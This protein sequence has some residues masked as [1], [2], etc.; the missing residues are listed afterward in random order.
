MLRTKKFF[1]AVAGLLLLATSA[2]FTEREPNAGIA[3]TPAQATDVIVVDNLQISQNTKLRPGLY[4]LRDEGAEGIIQIVGD[5][6]VVDAT[7]VTIVAADPNFAGYG[8]VASGRNNFTLRNITISG[9]KR[10]ARVEN[11]S[12]ARI[13][14]STITGTLFEDYGVV[15]SGSNSLTLRN[16]TI[17]GFKYGV[18]I[19]NASN[20]RIENSTITGNFKD[21][22]TCFLEINDG[23]RYGGGILFRNVSNSVV[24]GNKLYNQS[25]GLEMIGGANN[26]VL[27]NQ[28]SLGPALNEAQQNSCWGIRLDGSMNN[29]VRGNVADYVDRKR[30]PCTSECQGRGDCDVCLPQGSGSCLIAGD[31]AGIL[32]VSGSHRNQII[33]NSFTNSGDGFFIG[34]RFAGASNDNYVY[35]NDGSFSPSNAF[36][37]TFSRGNVFENNEAS[38]SN[39]GFWLGYS[40]GSRI[41]RNNIISNRTVGIEIE[42][43]YQNEIDHNVI[44]K[45]QF[46]MFLRADELCTN[47]LCDRRNPT[48]VCGR[49]CP[50]GDYSIHDNS[51]VNNLQRG[52][53]AGGDAGGIDAWHNNMLCGSPGQPCDHAAFNEMNRDRGIMAVRNWW[54]TT[55]PAEIKTKIFDHEDD[56]NKGYVTFEPSLPGLIEASV[57]PQVLA[58][59]ATKPLPIASSA[60]FDRRG[61]Q[62]VFHKNRIYVFG[63]ISGAQRLRNVYYGDLLP[64]GRVRAWTRT[65]DMPGPLHDHVVV[66]VG[67]HV[68]L[69]TGAA[70]ESAVYHNRIAAN[71]ALG[72]A[73]DLE[74]AR[75]SS[76]QSFAA[77]SYGDFIYVA[78]GNSTGVIKTVSYI[79]VKPDGHLECTDPDPTKCWRETLELPE[80]MQSHSLVAYD[81]RL[82]VIATDR[83]YVG[84]NL[85]N[86]IFFGP[87][88]SDGSL[89]SWA[90][91]T[92]RMPRELENYAA[93]ATDSKLYLFAG[94][95]STPSAPSAFVAPLTANGPTDPWQTTLNLPLAALLMGTRVGAYK[96]FVYTVGGFDGT[97]DKNVV[98]FGQLEIPGGCRG[99]ENLNVPFNGSGGRTSLTYDG[100][101][102][103]TVSGVGQASG[104]NYS[105]AFYVFAD[106]TGAPVT[107]THPNEFVLTING[108]PA[109]NFIKA[110]QAPGFRQ[111]HRYV[112]RINAPPGP[113]TFGVGD[114][115]PSDNTGSYRVGLCGGTP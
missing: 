42:H 80:P 1:T 77:A 112:F 74:T 47:P 97:T 96:D 66:R 18:R 93:F 63:G 62:L 24:Q 36:E 39:Y 100:L 110:Q 60:P 35:G 5:N 6:V 102:T 44:W 76:R 8:V 95:P 13:E 32:L 2:A 54:G 49:R 14:N 45:N 107:P 61:Q 50:S 108:Q 91:M 52:L 31:S 104:Q 106:G 19:E 48:D 98:Y 78:G 17:S 68:Y 114:G 55:V 71:G 58:W 33:S 72:P 51:I 85:E 25:T 9:F 99:G 81:A 87:L 59:S 109:H 57:G 88:K 89:G 43:G 65:T 113:L 30:Y 46:G 73:W 84:P 26:K 90:E 115:F 34:N 103:I 111:D 27:N 29:L 83:R 15:G 82:Y 105:D 94:T 41:T 4:R 23:E 70:G 86:K 11:T 3:A 12:G 20:V 101:A 38:S 40:Y 10:G 21:T 69:L 75:L 67:D 37:A 7:G 64:D 53:W 22:T 79:R 92:Q 28:T 16:I 56:E